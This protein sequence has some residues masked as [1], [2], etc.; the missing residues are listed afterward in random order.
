MLLLV[1][2][3]F[4]RSIVFIVVI[5]ATE[6][7][8]AGQQYASEDATLRSINATLAVDA[9]LVESNGTAIAEEAAP[10]DSI[11]P[12][13]VAGLEQMAYFGTPLSATPTISTLGSANPTASAARPSMPE[14]QQA[15][16]GHS[17]HQQVPV[18]STPSHVPKRRKSKDPVDHGQAAKATLTK[19]LAAETGVHKHGMKAFAE[20]AEISH[21]DHLSA[22]D[23]A[24]AKEALNSKVAAEIQSAL[25]AG[26]K[27]SVAQLG[28]LLHLAEE[29]AQVNED[30]IRVGL[31]SFCRRLL[32]EFQVALQQSDTHPLMAAI[33]S[34][35]QASQST[36]HCRGIEHQMQE[37][38][39][40]SQAIQDAHEVL[41][42]AHAKQNALS[43][44][45]SA[46]K[47][48]GIDK[49]RAA[50]VQAKEAECCSA[51]ELRPFE[52]DLYER[53]SKLADLKARL[54]DAARP[55]LES[56]RVLTEGEL[57]TLRITLVEAEK[58][59]LIHDDSDAWDQGR[60]ALR[61]AHRRLHE[62]F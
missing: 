36:S 39:G 23:R 46:M 1:S 43:A 59:W 54:A 18:A 47:S 41:E 26:S 32:L 12:S 14:R 25:R 7:H 16:S 50:M 22:N 44:L 24:I 57:E 37:L 11:V 15:P 48:R 33:E 19:A 17:V 62:E 51:D 21:S 2:P 58:T 45:T 3:S 40:F 42:W 6:R 4:A 13:S 56:Q 10:T 49:Y 29:R 52:H 34:A 35:E 53:E 31:E 5:F 8:V 60:L 55:V 20:L 38:S 28:K 27:V 30:I 9:S 61:E